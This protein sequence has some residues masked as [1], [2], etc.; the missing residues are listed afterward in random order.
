MY[1]KI[2]TISILPHALLIEHKVL[3]LFALLLVLHTQT[4]V[5]GFTGGMEGKDHGKKFRLFCCLL[6]NHRTVTLIDPILL[7]SLIE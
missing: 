7:T 6:K 4:K 1:L 5:S 3:K 2:C